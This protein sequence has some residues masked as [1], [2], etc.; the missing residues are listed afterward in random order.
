MS[1]S[2][3]PLGACGIDGVLASI[4]EA[5]D[6]GPCLV[7]RFDAPCGA[8]SSAVV[9]GGFV[10]TCGAIVN[11][12]V[13]KS[14]MADDPE[15]EMQA[16]LV[17]HGFEVDAGVGAAGASAGRTL[18]MLTAAFV[19]EVGFAECA[20]GD[21]G[22]S[23]ACWATVGLGNAARAGR[24]R[25]PAGGLFPGTINAV[26]VVDGGLAPGAYVG[27]AC[28]AAEAKAAA[29]GD[30]GVRDPD[31]GGAATGTTTDA[32]AIVATGRG[33]YARYAGTATHV[34]HAVGRAVYDAVYDSGRRY[35]AYVAAR[36]GG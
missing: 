6:G 34:G 10:E 19:R 33:A 26:V 14:Y 15:A 29:L 20:L 32:V 30:L 12:Q 11:R 25:E 36:R 17:R 3:R 18:G 35:L 24:L 22:R 16:F 27:A 21:G 7:V 13:P 8:L 1:A 31:D 4:L 28:V 9:G 2:E 5:D 23:V